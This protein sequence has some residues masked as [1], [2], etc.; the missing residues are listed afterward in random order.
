VGKQK[1]KVGDDRHRERVAWLNDFDLQKRTV[2]EPFYGVLEP[3]NNFAV[4]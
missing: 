3:P 1:G 2:T 4:L